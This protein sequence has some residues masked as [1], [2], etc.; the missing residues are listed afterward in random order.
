[1]RVREGVRQQVIFL[2]P[3]TCNLMPSLREESGI[4][5]DDP[6]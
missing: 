4:E 1:M 6:A 2:K 5:H 3:E